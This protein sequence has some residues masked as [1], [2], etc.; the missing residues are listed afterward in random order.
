V[1]GITSHTWTAK[2]SDGIANSQPFA[3]FVGK[4][5]GRYRAGQ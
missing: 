3:A 1:A 5:G 4:L 2:T